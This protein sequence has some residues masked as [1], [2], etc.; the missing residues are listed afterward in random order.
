MIFL[1]SEIRQWERQYASSGCS[2]SELGHLF[3][4]VQYVLGSKIWHEIPLPTEEQLKI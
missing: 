3:A 4:G 2:D 1:G